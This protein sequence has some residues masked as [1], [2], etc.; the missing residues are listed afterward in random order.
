MRPI[1][2]VE[3]ERILQ[4]LGG[5]PIDRVAWRVVGKGEHYERPDR[6]RMMCFDKAP[7]MRDRGV[8]PRGVMTQDLS[9]MRTGHLTVVGY[10]GRTEK[11]YTRSGVRGGGYHY[12]VCM[13]LCG[14][15][16]VMTGKALRR[17][18]RPDEGP[19]MCAACQSDA[20]KRRVQFY[21]ET[22]RWPDQEAA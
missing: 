21:R 14:L 12:W 5:I 16:T 9:G 1:S 7:P 2:S 4:E 20:N 22:G 15:F 8:G 13:C 3:A 10:W 11:K 17:I 19:L 18:R 6:L